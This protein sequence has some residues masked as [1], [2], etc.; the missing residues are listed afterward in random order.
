[1]SSSKITETTQYLTFM[2][3]HEVFAVDVAKVREI[4]DFTPATKVPGTPEFM[5]G[6]INVRGNV[7]PVVDMRLKFGMSQTQKTVDTCIVV[8]EISVDEDTTVL[9]ALVDSVQEVFELEPGQ[10][11]PPPRI[12]TRWRTEF[13]KGIGKHNNDLIIILDIDMVFLSG[14]LAAFENSEG[15]AETP[16]ETAAAVHGA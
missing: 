15:A 1:M 3:D 4:L 6:V 7:V 13:I 8:L 16:I 5:R 9:G 11:E 10:I 12:G 2:L 14:E